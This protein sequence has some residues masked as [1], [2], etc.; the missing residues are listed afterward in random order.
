M[1]QI[2]PGPCIFPALLEHK[3]VFHEPSQ[4]LRR[5]RLQPQRNSPPQRV[6]PPHQLNTTKETSPRQH[7]SLQPGYTPP[8]DE[9][10]RNGTDEN[11]P[12][13]IDFI[14]II[15]PGS[16]DATTITSTLPLRSRIARFIAWGY[17]VLGAVYA[18]SL[19]FRFAQ[20]A[21]GE[22]PSLGRIFA[23]GFAIIP[24][25]LI[26][27]VLIPGCCDVVNILFLSIIDCWPAALT[28]QEFL[29][30]LG[31]EVSLDYTRAILQK[32]NLPEVAAII[33]RRP[34]LEV[35]VYS[36]IYVVTYFACFFFSPAASLIKA[37]FWKVQAGFFVLFLAYLFTNLCIRSQQP[38]PNR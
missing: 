4:P 22:N 37:I 32:I 16:D 23:V 8:D 17:L 19:V 28:F 11:R 29:D 1:A 12:V 27:K 2:S 13:D 21:A 34:H 6:A 7:N 38:A 18:S 3:E 30:Q 33:P 15:P 20:F 35:Y 36:T 24:I 5:R 25:Y 26:L 9:N 14:T 31:T 10:N